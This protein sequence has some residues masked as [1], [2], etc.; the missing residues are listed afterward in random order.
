MKNPL[1][2]YHGPTCLDGL[3]AA[4]SIAGGCLREDI[5]GEGEGWTTLDYV[6]NDFDALFNKI[7]GE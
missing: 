6:S 4:A 7:K 1:V 3:F 5:G 2:V